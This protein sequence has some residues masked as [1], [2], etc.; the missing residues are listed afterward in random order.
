MS[1]LDAD[2]SDHTVSGVVKLIDIQ[3]AV[4]TNSIRQMEMG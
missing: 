4:R 1:A 2:E 3:L